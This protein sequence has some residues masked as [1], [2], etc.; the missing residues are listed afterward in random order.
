MIY[1]VYVDMKE[2]TWII[3]VLNNKWKDNSS[4]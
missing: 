2:A 4:I 1:P 3:I